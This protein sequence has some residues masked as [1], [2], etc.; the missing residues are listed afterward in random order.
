MRLGEQG[1]VTKAEL[2][3]GGALPVGIVNLVSAADYSH[4]PAAS[5][6]KRFDHDPALMGSQECADVL[7]AAGPAGG[8]KHRHSGGDCRPAGRRLVAEQ[9]ER[10]SIG[11]DE[12]IPRR[13]A[14]PREF[15]LFAEEPVTGMDQLGAGLLGCRQDRGVV[16]ISRRAGAGQADRFVGCVHVRAVCIVLGVDGDRVEA[17]TRLRCG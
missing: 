13:R 12:R 2:G 3:F 7:D 15:R 1:R 4:A 16:Q 8:R 9:F 11:P 17:P 10:G 5:A 14:R 6:G